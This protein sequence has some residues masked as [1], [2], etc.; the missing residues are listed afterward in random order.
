MTPPYTL[1]ESAQAIVFDLDGTLVDTFDDLALALD[2]ALCEFDLPPAPRD[3]VLADIHRGLDETARAIL[4]RYGTAPAV[5]EGVIAAYRKHYR[6]RA[7]A[8]SRLYPGVAEFL[9]LTWQR[10]CPMA[11]CTNKL[12][13]DARELLALL[14]IDGFFAEVT[15]IDAGGQA[16]PAPEPL[17]LTIR[18]LGSSPDVTLFVGDSEIDAQCAKN[19]GVTFLLHDAGFG[20]EAAAAI[21]CAGR[22]QAYAELHERKSAGTQAIA[23]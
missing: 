22:F 19:A 15:G 8:V 17:W 11:V 2:D 9:A 14:G 5:H 4:H 18:L 10:G 6:R 12:T 3:V 1:A 16:K 20:P 7:H 23:V 13:A 21:G